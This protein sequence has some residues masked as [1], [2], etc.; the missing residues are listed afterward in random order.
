MV[1]SAQNIEH[2]FTLFEINGKQHKNL[3]LLAYIVAYFNV[4]KVA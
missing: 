1:Y 2:Y 3:L 4:A